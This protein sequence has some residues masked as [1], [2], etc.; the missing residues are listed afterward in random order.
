M[1]RRC[2]FWDKSCIWT[3][4]WSDLF[5]WH[6]TGCY[7]LIFKFLS[8]LQQQDLSPRQCRPTQLELL[9]T[10]IQDPWRSCPSRSIVD[11]RNGCTQL[12]VGTACS[13]GFDCGS[14]CSCCSCKRQSICSQFGFAWLLLVADGFQ[15]RTIFR[16]LGIAKIKIILIIL[17]FLIII[18]LLF[19]KI[20]G[21]LTTSRP[22]VPQSSKLS[23]SQV[24]HL[25]GA[26]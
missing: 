5:Q 20:G 18:F 12:Q 25:S 8:I 16:W 21:V 9:G 10:T 6:L 7:S 15:A 26:A 17:L 2:F 14:C 22:E 19:W 23:A 24:Q 3:E 11:R 4:N 13:A 1:K